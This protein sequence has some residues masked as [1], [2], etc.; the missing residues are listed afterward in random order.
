MYFNRKLHPPKMS[1]ESMFGLVMLPVIIMLFLFAGHR[2]AFGFIAF[3]ELIAAALQVSFYIRTRN[4][5]FI[6]MALALGMIFIFALALS[7]YGIDRARS[8]APPL[9]M[10]VILAS[11]LII[12]IISKRKVKWRTR[13]ILELSAMPVSG[14]ENGFTERPLAAGRIEMTDLELESFAAFARENQIAIPYFE[15]DAVIFSLTSNYWKQIGLMDGYEDESWVRIDRDGQVSA[16]IS[17]S[18]YLKFK[19]HFSF[20]QLCQSL[21]ML[22]INFFELYKRG[23]GKKIIERCD[24]LGLNPFIE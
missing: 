10:L 6:W 7:V 14:M 13:E 18:Q 12:Y 17:K 19:S 9:S 23:E 20:D 5:H 22:F 4:I 2:V 8:M 21:G 3:V 1:I 11:I 15:E 24:N 16:S